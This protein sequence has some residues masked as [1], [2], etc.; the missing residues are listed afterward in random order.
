MLRAQKSQPV[1]SAAGLRF[2]VVGSRYNRRFTDALVNHATRTLHKAGA[3]R[4]DVKVVRVPGGFEIPVVVERLAANGN[5]DAIIALSVIIRGET[6]H[7]DL[8]GASITRELAGT[9]VRHGVP[10]IDE[11][12]LL[13]NEKQ[14]EVRC[15]KP[16][17]N[18]GTEAA[19]TAIEMARLMQ[20][21]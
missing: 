16:Q 6:A 15:V 11:V 21:L 10:I 4:A 19:L 8:I 14:A 20:E 9:A 5:V 1:L 17:H 18:R 13:Q 12:L 7:A 2:A 3:E